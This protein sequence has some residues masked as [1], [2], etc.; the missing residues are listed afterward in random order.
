MIK[1]WLCRHNYKTIS[2]DKTGEITCDWALNLRPERLLVQRCDKCGKTTESTWMTLADKLIKH[3]DLKAWL[4]D[5]KRFE[6]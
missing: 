4:E 2:F 1:Q 5:D 6:D 3:A